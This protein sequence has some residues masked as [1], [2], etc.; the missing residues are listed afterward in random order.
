MSL[1]VT[2]A[3]MRCASGWRYNLRG[4]HLHGVVLLETCAALIPPPADHVWLCF[5]SH[6]RASGSADVLHCK[7][8][9]EEALLAS[10]T[11]V[12]QGNIS[13]VHMH[14]RCLDC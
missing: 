14:L 11:A 2:F 8:R 3:A 5:L 6:A 12:A 13:A 1:L 10:A 9:V 4:M 7:P